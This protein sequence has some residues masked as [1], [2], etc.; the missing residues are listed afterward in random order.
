MTV[1]HKMMTTLAAVGFLAWQAGTAWAEGDPVTV[2]VDHAKMFRIQDEAST[3]IV[4]N[5]FIADVAMHDR[6]TVVITGKS[7]GT[8]N[9]IVLDANSVPIVDEMIIVKP[10]EENVVSVFRKTSRAS[11]SCAPTCQPT[12][13]VGDN[14]VYFDEL[15]KQSTGR[16][17]LA[18]EAANPSK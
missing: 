11:L 4:G 12:L 6:N 2:S 16:N 8:T 5:P 7:Y 3:V 13:R 15:L 10:S 17:L 1:K 18:I 9:L 14:G